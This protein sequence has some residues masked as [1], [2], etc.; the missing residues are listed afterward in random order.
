ML[1]AVEHGR[2]T[3][4]EDGLDTVRL[5]PKDIGAVE[6]IVCRPAEDERQVVAYARLDP[7]QGLSG[8][9]WQIRPNSRYTDGSPRPD[10]QLTLM[11]VRAAALVAGARERWPL[12]GD[13][14][15]VDLDLSQTNLPPGTA[16]HVGSAVLEVTDEPHHG[17]GKFARRF[18]VD[19]LKLVNSQAGRDLNLRGI[20]A[21]IVTGGT[22]RTGEMIRKTAPTARRRPTSGGG[23]IVGRR[24][25][26]LCLSPHDHEPPAR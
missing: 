26:R 10:T 22:I 23:L 25:S 3:P 16:L 15:F 17:C 4:L 9:N 12:A 20:Y 5:A 18:G 13:Q 1:P 14:L 2:L 6:L 21:R 7:D 11:N 8:D 24:A 19:A